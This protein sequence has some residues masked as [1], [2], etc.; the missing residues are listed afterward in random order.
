M[1]FHSYDLQK[2]RCPL[3]NTCTL[4]Q[5]L[6]CLLGLIKE[7]EMFPGKLCGLNRRQMESHSRAEGP[8]QDMSLSSAVLRE[9]CMRTQDRSWNA[10]V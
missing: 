1:W 3:E 5:R 9:Q 8:V 6:R 2:E 10:R 7:A 4:L